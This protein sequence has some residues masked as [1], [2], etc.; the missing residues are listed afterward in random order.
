VAAIKFWTRDRFKGTNDLKRHIIPTR[1]P[2]EHKESVRWLRNLEQS[3]ALLGEPERCLHVGDREADIFELFWTAEQTGTH[4]LFRTC[5]DRCAE[6]GTQLVEEAWSIVGA[7]LGQLAATMALML[8]VE[9]IIFGGGVM[10]DGL[11]LPHI[12]AAAAAAL[13]GYLQPLNHAGSLDRYITAPLLA[14]RAGITGAFLLAES[15]DP[16]H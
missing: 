4:F 16:K 14:G 3:T 7:Y 13:N 8:S 2:I 12:R 11:L 6:D 5:V 1:V 10:T 15:V 9:C